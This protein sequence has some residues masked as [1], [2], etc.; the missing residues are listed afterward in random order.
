M[1]LAASMAD[2]DVAT[3]MRERSVSV[4]GRERE[5]CSTG[6]VSGAFLIC[7]REVASEVGK[8]GSG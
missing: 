3:P 5:T 8:T 4:V 7:C 1:S 6:D 2:Q